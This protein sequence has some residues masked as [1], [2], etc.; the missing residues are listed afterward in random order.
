MLPATIKE[1]ARL[2][3]E[4]R[5]SCLE[6]T[7]SYLSRI[8]EIDPR[9]NA[10]ITVTRDMAQAQA[11]A[12]D[13]ELASGR[14]R[15]TLHGIPISLKDLID[16]RG[17][18]TTAASRIRTLAPAEAD[19]PVTQRLREAGAVFLGKCNLHEF[20]FGTTSEDS[21]FGP[22]RHPLDPAH[23]PGG[24]SGG[25]A[26]AVAAGLCVASIGT[27]TG[28]SI[29]IPA[30]ACGVVGLKPA[31][32]EISCEGVVPLS[33][34][35]D[36]VGPLARTVEDAWLLYRTMA[37]DALPDPERLSPLPTARIGIPRPYFFDRLHEGV[38]SGF[39]AR[40]V[41]L[42]RA[43]F[44]VIE[45]NVPHAADVPA[46]Y[47]H[48]QLAEAS[49]YHAAT[50]E[51]RPDDYTT[52][53]RRRLEMGRYILAED[54]L[55]AQRGRRIVA[56]DVERALNACDALALPT[57]PM[58]APPIGSEFVQL[59]SEREP[60]RAAM[61]R[62]TQAFN[63]S[64]HPAISIPAGV[65]EA[66]WPWGLQLVGKRGNTPGLLRLARSVEEI[67]LAPN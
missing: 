50:L 19:A 45:V 66:K 36:H 47:L 16:L 63:L 7:R 46:I 34:T 56:A 14:S 59:G 2:I 40:I 51:S 13:A 42:R 60:I 38:R 1:L 33:G 22:V 6:L 8:D 12:L 61:L 4:R 25:S 67:V 57:L 18:P 11:E 49:E 23:S 28:G 26:A 31:F 43:G 44:D 32:G 39:E 48:I 41:E 15:G 37:G 21:A 35:L 65:T 62:L 64:R 29:R 53:V 54:Y 30:A 3:H 52:S 58:P 27:D 17:V 20:A 5:I 10:Y 9:L 55:R 24:S